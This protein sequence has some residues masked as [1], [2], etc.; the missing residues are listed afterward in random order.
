ML[1]VRHLTGKDYQTGAVLAQ[2]IQ[3]TILTTWK[4]CSGDQSTA[5]LKDL[6]IVLI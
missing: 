6:W 3:R 4:H 2:C 5:I 1:G